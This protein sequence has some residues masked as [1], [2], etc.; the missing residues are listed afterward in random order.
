VVL[1]PYSR[2]TEPHTLAVAVAATSTELECLALAEAV[3]EVMENVG[4]CLLP[5]T[6]P[7]ILVAAAAADS[8]QAE[9]AEAAL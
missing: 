4:L 7:S 9:M 3:S 1:D 8:T 6:A 5:A 2:R